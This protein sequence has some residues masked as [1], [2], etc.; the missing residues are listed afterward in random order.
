MPDAAAACLAKT[1]HKADITL[2]GVNGIRE[3]SVH[4]AAEWSNLTGARV[5]IA[6]QQ[7]IHELRRVEAPDPGEGEMGS[8][9]KVDRVKV[10]GFL[11]GFI[12]D[13]EPDCSDPADKAR[14][15][16]DRFFATNGL[17]L[18]RN[19]EEQTV[20]IAAQVRE[21]KNGASISLVY[22]PPEHRGRGY[23]T[24]LVAGLSQ[25]ILDRGKTMCNLYTDLANPTSNAIYHRIG[26]RK[27]AENWAHRFE[28]AQG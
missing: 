19:G 2:K 24:R 18:W 22:T 27:I 5:E 16:A 9:T 21:S 8:A 1:L 23:A 10:E 11:A 20:S 14:H 3:A 13:T 28:P 12:A 7:G 6:M 26:Y 4:F 25:Q 17:Y 15:I